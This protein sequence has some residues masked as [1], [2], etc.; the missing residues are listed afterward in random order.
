MSAFKRA[1]G[2]TEAETIEMICDITDIVPFVLVI[3][4]PSERNGGLWMA[5][6]FA[7]RV[8]RVRHK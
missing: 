2:S 1:C 3:S 8:G 6:V 7:G 4:P 5:K